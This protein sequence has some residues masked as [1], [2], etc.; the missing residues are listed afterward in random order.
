MVERIEKLCFHSGPLVDQ[1]TYQLFCILN[2]ISVD[3][4]NKIHLHVLILWAR[5]INKYGL[6]CQ[7]LKINVNKTLFNPLYIDIFFL[8]V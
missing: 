7:M 3:M 2:V 4:I 5:E 8:Q 1:P 6:L